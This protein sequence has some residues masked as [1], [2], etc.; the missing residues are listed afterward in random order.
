MK[1]KAFYDEPFVAQQLFN[2]W[3]R[4]KNLTREVLIHTHF[5]M[6][7]PNLGDARLLI[8]VI[9][10]EGKEWDETP[11]QLTAPVHPEHGGHIKVEEVKVE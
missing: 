5:I 2:Q 7:G 6:I 4:G 8:V 11:I 10:P 3:A 1:L 9:H